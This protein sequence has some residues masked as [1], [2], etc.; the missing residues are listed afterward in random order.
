MTIDQP[1][2]PATQNDANAATDQHLL[3]RFARGRGGEA[4]AALHELAQ[5]HEHRLLGLALGLCDG[6]EDLAREVVQDTWLRVIRH[7]GTFKGRSS[8]A[9]WVYRIAVHR[10]RDTMARERGLARR[11]ARA[12]ARP[13]I[14][15][16]G[17]EGAR[18]A[19]AT[20]PLPEREVVL[21]CHMRGMTH[22]QAAAVLGIPPGT[23]KT[24]MAR[25]MRRLRDLMADERGDQ[26]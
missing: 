13:P 2:P 8:F 25:A 24:R 12:G 19:V 14:E 10:C 22:E 7:A 6:R 21:L 23:L 15:R 4:R 16:H 18:R 26:P 3:A 11:E 9:T 1:T 5:R 20:L 17:D